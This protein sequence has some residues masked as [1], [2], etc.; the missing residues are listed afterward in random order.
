M[1]TGSAWRTTLRAIAVKPNVTG[2]VLLARRATFNRCRYEPSPKTPTGARWPCAGSAANRK[3][4]D[5]FRAILDYSAHLQRQTPKIDYFATSLPAMLL[6]DEDLAR[7]QSITA[8]FLEAQAR[9]GLG[10]EAE[11]LRLLEEVLEMD[12][13]HAGAI[14]LLQFQRT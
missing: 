10:E 9:L 11:G 13:A 8:R 6:F 7:R 2:L 4:L 5:A 1:T 12:N 14:D 3:R